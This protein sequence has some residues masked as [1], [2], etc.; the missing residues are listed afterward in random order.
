MRSGGLFRP[1]RSYRELE[2]LEEISRAFEAM[3]DIRETYGRLTRQLAE[4]V[5]CEKCVIS[6]YEPETREFVCQWPGYN[7]ADELLKKV[8]YPADALRPAWNF[9]HRGPMVNKRTEEFNEEQRAFLRP[10][11][12]Y[13]LT[14]IPLF[15]EGR[16]VGKISIANKPGDCRRTT[17]GS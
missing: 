5:G 14:E 15:H 3:T 7:V 16:F 6:L 11:G 1:R 10:F 17:S 2:G 4:L 9:R 13:N 8:R 12:V